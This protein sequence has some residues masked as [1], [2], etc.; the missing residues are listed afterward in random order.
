VGK[1]VE[2]EYFPPPPELRELIKATAKAMTAGIAFRTEITSP[3]DSDRDLS[4]SSSL[5]LLKV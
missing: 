4:A 2:D 3:L 1:V 5:N